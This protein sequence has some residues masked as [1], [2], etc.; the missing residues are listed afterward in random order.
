LAASGQLATLT[1]SV[2]NLKA[3][4][5]QTR[6]QNLQL[7]FESSWSNDALSRFAQTVNTSMTAA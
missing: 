4:R 6:E 7:S 5:R 2:A 3:M 1:T